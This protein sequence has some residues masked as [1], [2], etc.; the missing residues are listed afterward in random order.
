MYRLLIVD[1]EEP[2]IEAIK[3]LGD[4][5]NLRI[6]EIMEAN[7]GQEGIAQ[8]RMNK[9]DLI[10]VDMKMPVMSGTEFLK[11]VNQDYPEIPVIVISGYNDFDY[12]RQAIK[13]DAVDY[14]L[15]PVNKKELNHTL[16]EA[17]AG[18]EQR[19]RERD[20][21][22]DRDITLNMSLPKLKEKIIMSILENRFQSNATNL[23]MIGADD[24][25]TQFGLAHIRIMNL[26][27]ILRL[28]FKD[29]TDLLYFSL[30]NV[31]NEEVSDEGVN[32]FS[33]NHPKREHELIA[34]YTFDA[35]QLETMEFRA[36]SSIGRA[37]NRLNSLFGISHTITQGSPDGQSIAGRRAAIR[38]ALEEGNLNYAEALVAEYT[39]KFKQAGYYSMGM[40]S[41]TLGEY[42]L[43][44]REIALELGVP[45]EELAM[46]CELALKERGVTFDY[47]SFDQFE[48]LLVAILSYYGDLI[49][50]SIQTLQ[51]FDI[52]DI[53][54]Y[55]HQHYAEE[56]RISLFTDKYYLS[57][58]Y[59][60]KLF[61]QEYGS[62][63]YEYVQKVR[64]EK[65]KD[66]LMD[67]RM[68]I[69]DISE[70]LGYKDKNYFSKAFKNYYQL[71]PS[72][73]RVSKL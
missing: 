61:K 36:Q 73:Y 54:E 8:I 66:L 21:H 53:K 16:S 23:A 47:V 71:S 13:S 52:Q 70:M 27:Q 40:A 50:K 35:T 56:I 38:H 28:R 19:R 59:L 31:I 22:I 20:E 7:N 12:A 68:K 43:M 65:A 29:D 34:I 30:T 60:M 42:T 37:L 39:G 48:Q 1:D 55:I 58:E 46:G 45:N 44:L 67:P 11:Q 64:M 17:I 26:K 5:D 32:C 62:G 57:R 2:L 4:W 25:G 63:I 3:I 51:H 10:L 15:K 33:F 24:P 18:L 69:Q 72:D 14:L 9:P 41:R 6:T 49:R